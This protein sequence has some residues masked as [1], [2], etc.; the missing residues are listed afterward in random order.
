MKRA[1]SFQTLYQTWRVVGRRAHSLHDASHV[2]LW[3]YL[4][5]GCVVQICVAGLGDGLSRAGFGRVGHACCC[6]CQAPRRLKCWLTCLSAEVQKRMQM[7][8]RAIINSQHLIGKIAP[9]RVSH[10]TSDAGA[11]AGLAPLLDHPLALVTCCPP[12]AA[13]RPLLPLRRLI[14]SI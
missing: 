14:A 11:R 4:G 13:S 9:G 1:V 2:S 10:L 7:C 12:D 8:K 5:V 6:F 3:A